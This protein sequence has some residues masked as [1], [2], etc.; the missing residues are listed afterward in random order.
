MLDTSWVNPRYF[1]AHDFLY[2]CAPAHTFVTSTL[3]I[4]CEV[5]VR[6]PKV[7]AST[8]NE[9]KF[10]IVWGAT[11]RCLEK[12]GWETGVNHQLTWGGGTQYAKNRHKLFNWGTRDQF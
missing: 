3:L 5:C 2:S 6:L 8:E 11:Q 1:C 4:F 9:I 12:T 7:E 10:I